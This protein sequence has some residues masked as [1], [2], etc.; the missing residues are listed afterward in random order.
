MK[1]I[2]KILIACATLGLLSCLAVNAQE[3]AN[4]MSKD[5]Q[6][7]NSQS[8]QASASAGADTGWHLDLRGNAFLYNLVTSG[9]VI[10]ATWHLK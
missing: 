5:T 3:T 10:G 6:T 7:L 4:A 9:A 8:G 2:R 1:S